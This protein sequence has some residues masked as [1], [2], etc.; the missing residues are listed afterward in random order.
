MFWSCK[1]MQEK[2]FSVG[3]NSVLAEIFDRQVVAATS[4]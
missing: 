4:G 3:L 2:G 1:K